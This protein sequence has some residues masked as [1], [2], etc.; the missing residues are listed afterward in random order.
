LFDTR[1]RSLVLCASKARSLNFCLYQKIGDR[2]VICFKSQDLECCLIQEIGAWNVM[3]FRKSQE[4]EL[5][6]NT[7]DRSLD[8]YVL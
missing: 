5:L 3:C 1:D 4:P 2:T 6:S 8:C 7:R